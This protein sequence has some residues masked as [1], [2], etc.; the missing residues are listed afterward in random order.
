MQK[1]RYVGEDRQRARLPFARGVVKGGLRAVASNGLPSSTCTLLEPASISI[2]LFSDRT[3]CSLSSYI[4]IQCLGQTLQPAGKVF[5]VTS[6][7]T[8]R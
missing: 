5:E 1:P 8:L 2:P 4:T 6:V 3:R 7:Q